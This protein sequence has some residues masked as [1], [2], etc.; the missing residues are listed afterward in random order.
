MASPKLTPDIRATGLKLRR[1]LAVFDLETTGTSTEL[2]RI[3]EIG[4]LKVAPD[5]GMVRFR[6]RLKPEIRI[7]REAT[8]VH[9]ITN[10]DVEDKPSFREI[11]RKVEKLLRGCDL[12]GFNL[13]S[14]D[15]LML[16]AEFG[17]AGID[18]DHDGYDV[19]DAKE[20]YH[21]KESRTLTDA[22]RFYCDS[23]HDEAHSALEDA[24]ATF[25][26]LEAQIAK[27]GLPRSVR[28]LSDY[29]D[30]QRSSKYLDS[31]KWFSTRDGKTVF[32]KGKH[33]GVSLSKIARE[34][35]DYLDWILALPDIAA[36][37]RKIIRKKIERT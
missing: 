23:T 6:Q 31:G 35:P 16:K 17:R 1:P 22:V 13:K 2:D 7:P 8:E 19:I 10:K 33:S 26:V 27:Y 28:Q 32:A 5:G 37:T 21:L 11:A 15:L 20:I 30:G 34:S 12:A 29:L 9:G 36:D 18:F 25:R 3:V 14:F 24:C 4:I